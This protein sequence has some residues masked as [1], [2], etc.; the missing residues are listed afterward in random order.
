MQHINYV[1]LV[2]VVPYY[3]AMA[4]FFWLG[5]PRTCERVMK[6]QRVERGVIKAKIGT[7]VYVIDNI[8]VTID[9]NVYKGISPITFSWYHN[10]TFDQSRGNVSSITITV[11]NATV[12]DGHVYTCK[13]ENRRGSDTL[14]ST[15]VHNW[16]F[17]IAT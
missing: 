9:C 8:N 2:I 11:T 16:G 13:A 1:F 3:V 15:L 4:M 12:I 10:G 6:P 5:A 14:N 17:C 7:P